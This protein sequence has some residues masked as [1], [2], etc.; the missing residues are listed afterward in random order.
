M[1][2]LFF[3]LS[4]KRSN[5]LFPLRHM[6]N[7]A[8]PSVKLKTT[9]YITG[10]GAS[11]TFLK[12]DF[13]DGVKRLLAF[14]SGLCQNCCS[15][16]FCHCTQSTQSTVIWPQSIHSTVIWPQSIHSTVIWPQSI[17]STVYWL[18]SDDSTVKS[19]HSQHTMLSSDHSQYT[20]LSSDHNDYTSNLSSDYSDYTILSSDTMI[21]KWK[22]HFTVSS[23]VFCSTTHPQHFTVTFIHSISQ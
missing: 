3:Q 7:I 6:A 18:W 5:F 2:C 21:P 1:L 8:K 19:D 23:T 16:A 20:V 10:Q 11:P 17:H 9:K 22:Q 12:E 15:P 13:H 14:L 4:H